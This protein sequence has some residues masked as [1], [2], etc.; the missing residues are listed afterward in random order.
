LGRNALR[1]PGFSQLDLQ[2]TRRFVL[3][4]GCHLEFRAEVFNLLNHANF[5]NPNI[6]LPD[7]T[8]DAQPGTAYTRDLAAGFGVL[9]STIGRT[10]GL[11]TSRQFQLSARFQF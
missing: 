6:V 1:G 9:N 8:I 10:V 11:G 5:S 2:V 4:G 3:A 7:S